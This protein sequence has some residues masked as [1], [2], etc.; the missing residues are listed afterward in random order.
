MGCDGASYLRSKQDHNISYPI[1]KVN[2]DLWKC[3]MTMR[4]SISK[5]RGISIM[6]GDIVVYR[7]K[8][9][10]WYQFPPMEIANYKWDT[11]ETNILVFPVGNN[12]ETINSF[13]D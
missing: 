7:D 1:D 12:W 11:V 5:N 4:D 13:P 9:V 10:N 6:W 2:A 8:E 3:I